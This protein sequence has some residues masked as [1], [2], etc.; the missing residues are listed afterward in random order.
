MRM[1]RKFLSDDSNCNYAVEAQKIFLSTFNSEIFL[2]RLYVFSFLSNSYFQ[3]HQ[4]VIMKLFIK[5]CFSP[6]VSGLMLLCRQTDLARLLSTNSK[7][8]FL[9]IT[10]VI[11][12]VDISN[13]SHIA[14][15][16]YMVIVWSWPW[17]WTSRS[18]KICFWKYF[19]L[20]IL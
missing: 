12:V 9:A 8:P 18:W 2:F 17:P 14:G 13:I 20:Y 7:I 15:Y 11:Y 16:G 4:I 10:L 6:I 5:L 19:Y 1:Y 3:I